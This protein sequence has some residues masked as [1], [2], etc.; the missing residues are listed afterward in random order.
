L[1]G[2]KSIAKKITKEKNEGNTF[3]IPPI[4]YYEIN[5]WLLKNN[6]KSKAEIFRKIYSVNGIGSISKEVLDIASSIY[7]IL[8]KNGTIIETSDILIAAWCI[9]NGYILVSNNKKHF[10]NI[11][12]LNVEN[13][14]E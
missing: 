11:D 12:K 2:N 5:N 3:V 1:K 10:I 14:F 4:V 6:S 7:D 8:R 13:W 9:R